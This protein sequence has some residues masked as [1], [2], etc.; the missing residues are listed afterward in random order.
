L[1]HAENLE[2][3]IYDLAIANGGIF[4]PKNDP[5]TGIDWLEASDVFSQSIETLLAGFVP[6]GGG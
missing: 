1:N 3:A 2:Q 5:V 6:G 4:T